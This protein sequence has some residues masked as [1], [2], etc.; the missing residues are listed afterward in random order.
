MHERFTAKFIFIFLDKIHF[1]R[2]VEAT[3]R[4]AKIH[5]AGKSEVA[6]LATGLGSEAGHPSRPL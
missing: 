6:T 1:V 4:D 2:D 3:C 5:I